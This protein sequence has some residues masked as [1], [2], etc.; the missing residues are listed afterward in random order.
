MP[1]RCSPPSAPLAGLSAEDFASE[2]S[3]YQMGRPP[4]RVDILTSIAGVRFAGAW[5]T[6]VPTDLN[7]VPVPF[8]ARADLVANKRAAGRPQDL[9]DLANL[10]ADA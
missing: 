8:L 3:I 1:W 6:R 5:P 9:L 7:G 10:L 2:G 4:I